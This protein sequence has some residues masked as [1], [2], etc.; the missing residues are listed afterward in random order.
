MRTE[1]TNY[2]GDW[3]AICEFCGEPQIYHQVD[4]GVYENIRHIHRQPCEQEQHEILKGVVARANATRAI[5]FVYE[6]GKYL[7]DKVPFKVEMKLAHRWSR[8]FYVG[9]RGWYRLQ[10]RAPK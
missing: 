3:N 8:E 9:I 4:L 2:E 7:W 6:I 10:K 5:V 1:S